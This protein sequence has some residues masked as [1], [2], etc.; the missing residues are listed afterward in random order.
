MEADT[1]KTVYNFAK[2]KE[3]ARKIGSTPADKVERPTYH[4]VKL[5]TKSPSV[6][7]ILYGIK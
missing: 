4:S 2:L 3:Q 6:K 5:T 1:K 7:K